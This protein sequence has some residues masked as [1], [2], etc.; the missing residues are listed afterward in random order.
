MKIIES[1]GHFFWE[2]PWLSCF[3]HGPFP[4]KQEAV[5]SYAATKAM[6]RRMVREWFPTL[7]DYVWCEP[8]GFMRFPAQVVKEALASDYDW[9]IEALEGRSVRLVMGYEISPMTDM[10]VIAVAAA[11]PEITF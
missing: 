3:T 2:D 7:G 1:N 8:Q 11:Y 9:V 10:E 6:G 5:K 4:S